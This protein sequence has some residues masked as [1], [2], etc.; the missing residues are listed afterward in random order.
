MD[1]YAIKHRAGWLACETWSIPRA[2]AW[3]EAFDAKMYVD[4]TLRREDFYIVDRL[5]SKEVPA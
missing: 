3:I 2:K 4:K 1:R 5:T